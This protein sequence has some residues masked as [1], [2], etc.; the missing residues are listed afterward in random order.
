MAPPT[1][2]KKPGVAV[3]I[4]IGPAPK[5][6]KMAMTDEA[7]EA[8]GAEEDGA[9]EDPKALAGTALAKALGLK[10]DGAAVA[11]AFEELLAVLDEQGEAEPTDELPVEDDAD[12]SLT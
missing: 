10:V 3:A 11:A 9:M 4:G 2:G 1:K 8:F 12:M 5:G 7:P 6:D